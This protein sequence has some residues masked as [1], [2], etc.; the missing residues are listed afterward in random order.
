MTTYLYWAME[1]DDTDLETTVE[2]ISRPVVSSWMPR[3]VY[4]EPWQ[5]EDD[6]LWLYMTNPHHGG[7]ITDRYGCFIKEYFWDESRT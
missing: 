6:V 5:L 3:L 4:A 2:Y 1:H 7:K